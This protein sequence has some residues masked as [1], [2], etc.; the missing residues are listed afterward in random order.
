[1]Q[2]Y[3]PETARYSRPVPPDWDPLLS[4]TQAM[5]TEYT[6]PRPRPSL[7]VGRAVVG[8]CERLDLEALDDNRYHALGHVMCGLASALDKPELQLSL[9]KDMAG[10]LVTSNDRHDGKRNPEGLE[11][12]EVVGSATRQP[13]RHSVLAANAMLEPDVRL[14]GDALTLAAAR[15]RRQQLGKPLSSELHVDTIY[16]G[17]QAARAV[18]TAVTSATTA[19]FRSVLKKR[20]DALPENAKRAIAPLEDHHNPTISDILRVGGGHESL[21]FERNASRAAGL[22]LDEI[23]SLLPSLLYVNA[24]GVVAFDRKRMPHTSTLQQSASVPG[25]A[26]VRRLKC[27]ALYVEGLIEIV[28]SMVPAAVTEADDLL[29]KMSRL[30]PGTS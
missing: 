26:H 12:D 4:A 27:P 17:G 2:G 14:L 25:L 21:N 16:E 7:E 1:M 28:A 18:T 29:Q 5:L 15:R 3:P 8:L 11:V 23:S 19:V 20:Y 24:D 22:R 6:P 13:F 9:I 30:A 10:Q